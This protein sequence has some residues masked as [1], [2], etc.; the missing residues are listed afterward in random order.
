MEYTNINTINIA[1][2]KESIAQG[3]LTNSK[4]PNRFIKGI[5]PT[6][7]KKGFKCYLYDENNVKYIDFICGL[8]ANLFGYGNRRIIDKVMYGQ[9]CGACHSLP[10]IYELEAA[11][12]IKACFPFVDIVKFVN[13]GSSAC[14][15]ALLMAQTFTGRENFIQEGYH[16]WHRHFW[17]GKLYKTIEKGDFESLTDYK[18]A[19]VI[20]EPVQLDDSR[21]RVEWLKSLRKW[22]DKNKIILIFDEII[23][24]L[25]FNKLSV[26]TKYDIYPDIML[27][28]K[29]LGNG[30]KIAAVCGR[31]DILDSPNYFCSGTFQGNVP[32]LLA[33][34]H[35]LNLATNSNLCSQEVL[36]HEGLQ[37][38]EKF[39][40]LTK[41]YFWL[42]GYGSRNAFKGD[43]DKLAIFMQEMAKAR[44]LIGASFFINFDLLKH[45][46]E[47]LDY[48]RYVINRIDSIKLE[49][50]MFSA[51]FSSKV[52]S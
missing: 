23:T 30:E 10:T 45:L 48:T 33:V 2:S 42:E 41:P 24:G 49:G 50:E 26:A 39:N 35:T 46:D 15:A 36:N 6:H 47:L 17:D 22:C 13:D 11:E 31:K 3:C 1:R 8:G 28:S 40:K 9:Y 51:A 19:C 34:T 21:P 14:S 37:F 16:G 20:V 7:I 12:K 5:Y 25:R 29:A 27:L 43:Q 18:P 38:I 52:R 32:G 44:I 4:H